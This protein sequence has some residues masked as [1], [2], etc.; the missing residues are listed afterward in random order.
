MKYTGK[1]LQNTSRLRINLILEKIFR[2]GFSSV[3]GGRYIRS[4]GDKKINIDAINWHGCG[5]SQFL[6]NENMKL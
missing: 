1:N 2:D 6:L 5:M 3:L 4:K